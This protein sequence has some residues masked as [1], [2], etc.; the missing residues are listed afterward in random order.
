MSLLAYDRVLDGE[1]PD[2]VDTRRAAREF[3]A[4][5]RKRSVTF[6]L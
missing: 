2:S 5:H 3:E 6:F 4:R 1:I